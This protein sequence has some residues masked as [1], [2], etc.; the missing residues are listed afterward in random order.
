M[1]LAGLCS[2]SKFKD[3]LILRKSSSNS[4]LRIRKVLLLYPNMRPPTSTEFS[5]F[6]STRLLELGP[7]MSNY[8]TTDFAYLSLNSLFT[9]TPPS[10]LHELKFRQ[11]RHTKYRVFTKEFYDFKS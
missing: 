4:F 1:Q 11:Q 8:V 9:K 6:S 7:M 10:T 2:K 5:W 3:R